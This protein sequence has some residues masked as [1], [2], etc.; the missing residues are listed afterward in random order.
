MHGHRIAAKGVQHQEVE[1]L[2][3]LAFERQPRI[4]HHDVDRR[5][6]IPRIAKIEKVR[7]GHIAH[8]RID[9]IKRKVVAGPRET[10]QR[11][12]P[13]ADHAHA[14]RRSALLAMPGW[15]G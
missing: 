7:L 10:G 13:Q 8:G 4:A 12:D 9:F 11:A 6:A 2:R 3:R 1:V 15:Q 5:A 14:Q